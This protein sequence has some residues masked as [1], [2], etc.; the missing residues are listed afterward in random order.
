M[1]SKRLIKALYTSLFRLAK[2]FDNDALSKSILRRN[3]LPESETQYSASSVYYNSIVDKLIGRNKYFYSYFDKNLS[4]FADIVRYEF[5]VK[6]PEYK[7]TDRTEVAFRMIRKL[8]KIWKNYSKMMFTNKSLGKMLDEPLNEHAIDKLDVKLSKSIRPGTILL[9]HPLVHE[10]HRKLVVVVLAHDEKLSYGV[11]LNRPRHWKLNEALNGLSQR[12]LDL[13][14]DQLVSYGG[15]SRRT[16]IIH[17][18]PNI[19]GIPIPIV[20]VYNHDP[21]SASSSPDTPPAITTTDTA[22]TRGTDRH[23]TQW[24][25]G[26]DIN[27]IYETFDNTIDASEVIEENMTIYVGSCC[28]EKN[29]LAAEVENG[30]WIPVDVA[31]DQVRGLVEQY[32]ESKNANY[33]RYDDSDADDPLTLMTSDES[34]EAD[35]DLDPTHIPSF[36]GTADVSPMVQ[37]EQAIDQGTKREYIIQSP[38][39]NYNLKIFKVVREEVHSRDETGQSFTGLQD[40]KDIR[41]LIWKHLLLSLDHES[42]QLGRLPSWVDNQT[43]PTLD[44]DD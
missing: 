4:S 29:A 7:P 31:F 30:L 5:R 18:L 35:S 28:W 26:A 43:L 41:F 23:E 17:K 1:T 22:G 27:K 38:R 42:S 39:G 19:G 2:R 9:A 14:A 15:N 10:S 3:Y 21:S 40:K 20:P 44:Y 33:I 25:F 13:F 37:D 32:K 36:T 11:V 8:S 12:F 16:Q 24:Y 6:L 34:D